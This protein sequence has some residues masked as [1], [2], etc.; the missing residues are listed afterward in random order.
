MGLQ[1]IKSE[2]EAKLEMNNDNAAMA[3][4]KMKKA[5]FQGTI[6]VFKIR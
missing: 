5:N 6:V 3:Q 2:L 4:P 1:N